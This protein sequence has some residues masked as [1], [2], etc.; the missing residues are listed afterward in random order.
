MPSTPPSVSFSPTVTSSPTT[1]DEFKPDGNGSAP[2]VVGSNNGLSTGAIAG[3]SVA[4][5]LCVLCGL[6]AATRRPREESE[7]EAHEPEH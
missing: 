4:A 2:P 5:G 3:I 7:E 1:D 6:L